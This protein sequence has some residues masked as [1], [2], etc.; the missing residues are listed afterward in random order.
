[1]QRPDHNVR[2]GQSLFFRLAVFLFFVSILEGGKTELFIGR[3]PLQ[4]CADIFYIEE[5]GPQLLVFWETGKEI[6]Y[7]VVNRFAQGANGR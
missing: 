3:I 7:G 4:M 1:M 2:P 5:M 6:V